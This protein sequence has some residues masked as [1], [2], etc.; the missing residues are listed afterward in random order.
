MKTVWRIEMRERRK[1]YLE[2]NG[3]QQNSPNPEAKPEKTTNDQR[4]VPQHPANRPDNR[5]KGREEDQETTKRKEER[6][7]DQKSK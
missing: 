2:R 5:K 3:V 1:V 6:K 4:T 7:D